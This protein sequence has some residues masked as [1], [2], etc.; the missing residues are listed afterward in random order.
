MKGFYKY[1]TFYGRYWCRLFMPLL[2]NSQVYSDVLDVYLKLQV[3]ERALELFDKANGFDNYILRTPVHEFK[4]N[5]ALKLR[6][7]MLLSLVKED[8]YPNDAER[9]AYIKEKYKDCIIPE[10]EAD[11]IGL[12]EEEAL[13]KLKLQESKE[14][15]ILP[16]KYAFKKELVQVLTHRQEKGLLTVQKPESSLRSSISSFFSPIFRRTGKSSS[17]QSMQ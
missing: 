4:S 6:R 11:W 13:E 5:L 14:N 7:K 1:R 17:Q 9:H 12:T 8:Y 15:P 10:E 16:M 3:N 2:Y